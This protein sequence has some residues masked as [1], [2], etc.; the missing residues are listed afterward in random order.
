MC[1]TKVKTVGIFTNKKAL[2]KERAL[3]YLY[4][5]CYF[6]ASWNPEVPA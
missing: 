2:S 1:G 4:K 6:K 5:R 3:N